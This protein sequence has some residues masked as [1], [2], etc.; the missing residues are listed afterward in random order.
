MPH[1]QK[2]NKQQK[3]PQS[4]KA[5]GLANANHLFETGE[6]LANHHLEAQRKAQGRPQQS[7]QAR[8]NQENPEQ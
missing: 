2:K 3:R 4:P 7:N 5:S 1:D 8:K 6:E